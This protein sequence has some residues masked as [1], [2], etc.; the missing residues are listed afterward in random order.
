[1]RKE[2]NPKKRKEMES[3]GW[4]FSHEIRYPGQPEN[5]FTESF[6]KPSRDGVYDFRTFDWKVE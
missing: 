2:Y 4:K 6:Y 1:M 3:K 5:W